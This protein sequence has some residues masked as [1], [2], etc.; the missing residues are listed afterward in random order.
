MICNYCGNKLE[1][2]DDAIEFVGKFY[3][4]EDCLHHDVD[5]HSNWIVVDDG[6]EEQ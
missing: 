3:C 2:G 5:E 6:E 1:D 4:D